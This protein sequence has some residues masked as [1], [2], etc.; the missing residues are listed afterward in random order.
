MQTLQTWPWKHV[1]EGMIHNFGH[2]DT[3]IDPRTVDE[4]DPRL[5]TYE[6]PLPGFT[7]ALELPEERESWYQW[8]Q[9][10]GYDISDHEKF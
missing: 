5:R 8:L 2:T 4:N 1:L 6:G 10:R 9:E 3:T 7:V